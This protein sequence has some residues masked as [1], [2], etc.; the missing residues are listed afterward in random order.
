VPGRDDGHEHGHAAG[1]QQIDA[2]AM[3][4][5]HEQK[6]GHIPGVEIGHTAAEQDKRP[7]H[8]ATHGVFYG[9]IRTGGQKQGNGGQGRAADEEAAPGLGDADR[10]QM[11]V[12]IIEDRD[13]A[14]REE[15]HEA[16]GKKIKRIEWIG[17]FH[18]EDSTGWS[19]LPG[20]AP[21]PFSTNPATT[22][23]MTSMSAGA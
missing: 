12:K 23:A 2:H 6:S 17:F 11:L 8:G 10:L 16:D 3:G 19:F 21:R 7:E 22:R 20:Q 14:V 15:S 5:A 1:G 13:V 18:R 9:H 4:Q